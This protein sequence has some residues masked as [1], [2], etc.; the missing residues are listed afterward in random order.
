MCPDLELNPRPFCLRDDTLANWATLARALGTVFH[1]NLFQS[2]KTN[3]EKVFGVK[4]YVHRTIYSPWQKLC[5]RTT[6]KSQ[7]KKIQDPI[8]FSILLVRAECSP[9]N[10][11]VDYRHSRVISLMPGLTLTTHPSAGEGWNDP[12]ATNSSFYMFKIIWQQMKL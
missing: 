5:E 6:N 12:F 9:R 1:L 3:H 10:R 11:K 2:D 4:Y 7:N 8:S